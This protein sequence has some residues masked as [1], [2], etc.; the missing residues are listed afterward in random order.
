M[1]MRKI[2]AFDAETF[3]ALTLLARGSLKAGVKTSPAAP[4]KGAHRRKAPAKPV[5]PT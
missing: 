5:R 3:D 4:L 2:I 1:R